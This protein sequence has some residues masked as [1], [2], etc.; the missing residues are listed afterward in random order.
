MEDLAHRDG[1]GGDD[2]RDHLEKILSLSREKLVDAEEDIERLRL[3]LGKVCV[4][5]G[6]GCMSSTL[7][8]GDV[9]RQSK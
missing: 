1:H 5:F 6:L 9:S 2:E 8:M 4:F 3:G 7:C